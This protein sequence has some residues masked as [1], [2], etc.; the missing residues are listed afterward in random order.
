[1]GKTFQDRIRGFLAEPTRNKFLIGIVVL[2]SGSWC[3]LSAAFGFLKAGVVGVL[4][5]AFLGAIFGF[6]NGIVIAALIAANVWLF[7]SLFLEKGPFREMWR[8]RR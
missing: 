5:G 2:F 3:I 6:V 8:N 4:V 7:A 1:M